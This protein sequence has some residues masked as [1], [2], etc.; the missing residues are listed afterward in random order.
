MNVR[1]VQAQTTNQKRVEELFLKKSKGL[2]EEFN[3]WDCL[4]KESS[5]GS[6]RKKF[7]TEN[8]VMGII[9]SSETVLTVL[10]HGLKMLGNA[11]LSQ[12]LWL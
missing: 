12:F 2:K 10:R 9:I 8:Q 4:P 3:T 5:L 6:I 11:H 7:S 1:G